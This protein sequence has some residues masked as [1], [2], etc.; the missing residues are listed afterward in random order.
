MTAPVTWTPDAEAAFSRLKG[1]L[2]ATTT[3]AAAILDFDAR[4][5]RKAVA[6]GTIPSV[7]VGA[8]RRIPVAWIRQQVGMGADGGPDAP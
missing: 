2:F 1:R 8:T 7:Q 3:E 5:V 6:A 4:T